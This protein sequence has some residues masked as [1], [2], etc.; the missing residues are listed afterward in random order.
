MSSTAF[1]VAD[2]ESTHIPSESSPG[3]HN[4]NTPQP[5]AIPAS[6]H[7]DQGQ[8]QEHYISGP[9]TRY[10]IPPYHSSFTK[11]GRSY[12][13]EEKYDPDPL[14]DE[15]K[16]NARVWK[17]YLDEAESHDLEMIT[18]FRDTI[19]A[20]LVFAALFS[21]VVTSFIIAAIS[22]LQ[23]DFGKIT[24][25]L[26]LEQR[27]LLRAAGNMTT[28]N[29]IPKALVDLQNASPGTNDIWINGL[30]FT[31]LALSLATALLSVLVKQ[32][33]QAYENLPSGNAKERA[34][35]HYFR[36]TGLINW[37]V[38]EIIGI[39]PLILHMSLGLF[40]IGLS[41]YVFQLH[42]TLSWIV[43]A[44]TIIAFIIYL[45]SIILPSIRLDC[46]YR[47]P[48]LFTLGG[49]IKYVFAVIVWYMKWV[50]SK[51]WDLYWDLEF[52]SFQLK[53]LR[54]AELTHFT[55][56]DQENAILAKILG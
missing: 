13:Y 38:P 24:A 43:I 5:G 35:I 14:G 18:G 50:N 22:S 11:S 10:M 40:L 42:S 2:Q 20:L 12:D 46:P 51:I 53:T 47:I 41:L 55:S 17:V 16:E 3:F 19:D 26:L 31:S 1:P 37:K 28:I 33:L 36:Y 32:W 7:T 54:N 29:S 39:L 48:L 30:F 9:R 44:V 23:P 6:A 4:E 49:Y 27:D 8:F 52:P 15:M 34:M 45:G 21:A 56:D 25:I